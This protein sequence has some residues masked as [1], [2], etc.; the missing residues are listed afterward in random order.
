MAR[1]R[2]G[3][4]GGRAAGRASEASDPSDPGPPT[5]REPSRGPPSSAAGSAPAAADRLARYRDKRD[6]LATNEPFGPVRREGDRQP[7]RRGVFVVHQ[8]D[9]SRMHWDLRL[10]MA[11]AL[12]S[13]AV[14]KGP[15]L[16]PKEKRLAVHTEPHPLDYLDFEAVIPPGNYGAGAMI[17]WD[18]GVVEYPEAPGEDGLRAGKVDFLLY[19]TKLRGRFA[20]VRTSGRGARGSNPR[21]PESWLLLKKTDP[22][23][24]EP[25]SPELVDEAPWSLLSGLRVDELPEAQALAEELVREATRRGA[26]AGDVDGRALTPMRAAMEGAPLADPAWLYELK[27]DGVRLLADK[28]PS[29]GGGRSQVALAYRTGRP[30]TAA[31]PEIARAIEAIPGERLVL[32]G[33][34]VTFDDEGRPSFQRLGSR[35]HAQ[36]GRE[37]RIAQESVPVRYLVFDL[38]QL[39]DRD[40]RPLPLTD[41][42]A[43]LGELVRG[44][45]LVRTL[46]HLAGDGRAL[47]AFC[48]RNRLEGIMAKRGDAPY[49]EG[50]RR[51]ATWV[52]VKCER[53][54]DFVVLGWTPGEG[55][56]D[57]LGALVVGSREPGL[58][59]KADG[60]PRWVE[61]GRV[62]S[63]FDRAA[64]DDWGERLAAL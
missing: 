54:D 27:L 35:L 7:T 2:S 57:A 55:A 46:D 15:S 9:A 30:A 43:L 59:G 58:P 45:G 10:E 13:F 44:K 6:P 32:D 41:R 24:R 29:G 34:L 63:G 61:R 49:R 51:S 4:G 52:K 16:S 62:G 60:P 38:L 47:L 1:S 14:P 50:P 5:R 28:R 39:G 23:A 18:R 8:H 40:L 12:E 25:G 21:G 26:F 53:T 31:F 20:L 11:G 64:L 48:T 33:E 42:K 36:R 17:V 22:H 3:T 56:R 19:G 37:R